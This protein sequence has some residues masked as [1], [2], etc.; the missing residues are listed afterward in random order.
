MGRAS[1]GTGAQVALGTRAIVPEDWKLLRGLL[2]ALGV[3]FVV[4]GVLALTDMRWV[5]GPSLALAY[6]QYIGAPLLVLAGAVVVWWRVRRFRVIA[7]IVGATSLVVVGLNIAQAVMIDRLLEEF[8]TVFPEP[9]TDR[10]SCDEVVATAFPGRA[11]LVPPTGEVRGF[12]FQGGEPQGPRVLFTY[13]EPAAAA[14]SLL[15]V[16]APRGPDGLQPPA[17]EA[18]FLRTPGGVAHVE[19]REDGRVERIDFWDDDFHYVVSLQG[20][21]DSADEQH[22]AAIELVDSARRPGPRR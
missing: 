5:Q 7:A 22:A 20:G 14:P 15:F 12:R 8:Q 21:P 13:G 1:A 17:D 2:R 16:I 6:V 18:A 10:R 19:Q 4:A 3:L 9:C 11:P